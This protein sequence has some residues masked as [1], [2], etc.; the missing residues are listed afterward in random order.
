MRHRLLLAA[1]AALL[2]AAG[3]PPAAAQGVAPPELARL[4][5]VRDTALISFNGRPLQV[6]EREW[7]S[8]NRVHGVCQDLAT[9]SIGDLRLIAGTVVEFVLFDGTRYE[10]L[11]EQTAWAASPDP[12]FAPDQ[13]LNAAFFTVSER[14]QLSQLGPASVGGA[15]ATHYQYWVL[16][17]E[18]NAAAG[19]Q[20]VYDQFVSPQGYVLQSQVAARGAIPGL[21]DG[22]L[23]ELR[24]FRD[25]NAPITVAPPAP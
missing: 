3:A 20:L 9:A 22:E 17:A 18:A 2:L 11:N 10:R 12:G 5:S 25:F 7:Q 23:S 6:C 14:A 21:G 19:G 24:S 16:D 15:P 1:L 13:D 4:R 8:W